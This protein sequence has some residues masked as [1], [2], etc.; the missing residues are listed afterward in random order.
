MLRQNPHPDFEAQE[1]LVRFLFVTDPAV[2]RS[3]DHPA[4]IFFFGKHR[5]TNAGVVVYWSPACTTCS[6]AAG[7]SSTNLSINEES[8]PF[9]RSR[10]REKEPPIFIIFKAIKER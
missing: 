7:S 5:P 10:E 8:P 9:Q 6:H 4:I 1:F 2:S 3:K